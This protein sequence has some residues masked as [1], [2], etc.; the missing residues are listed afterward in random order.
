MK[1]VPPNHTD[2]ASTAAAAAAGDIKGMRGVD[3]DDSLS[4][5]DVVD[6]TG[7]DSPIILIEDESD[8]E[9]GRLSA[10]TVQ[11]QRKSSDT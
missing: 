1:S 5:V 3:G 10:S 8:D 4:D 11:T 9:N 6:L 2:E 7:P